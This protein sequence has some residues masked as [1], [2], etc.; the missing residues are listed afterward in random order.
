[1]TDSSITIHDYQGVDMNCEC[2]VCGHEMVVERGLQLSLHGN[3]V[4]FHCGEKEAPRET[5]AVTAW[6]EK[7]LNMQEQQEAERHR[8]ELER[9]AEIR[10]V[11]WMAANENEPGIDI[12]R[13][14]E[15]M[16]L[17]GDVVLYIGEHTSMS[18]VQDALAHMSETLESSDDWAINQPIPF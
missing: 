9:K 14:H 12:G 1:M 2:S 11:T 18:T 8:A 5:A 7:H 13:E 17:F 3:P 16:T 10:K 15:L 4:C 6:H